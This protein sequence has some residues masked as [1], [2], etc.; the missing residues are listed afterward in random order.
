MITNRILC[1]GALVQRRDHQRD[2]DARGPLTR[3]THRH[4]ARQLPDCY[5]PLHIVTQLVN[6][7]DKMLK[8]FSE[9]SASGS[10]QY[11]PHLFDKVTACNAF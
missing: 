5:L 4:T 11:E 3:R 2:T 8:S 9:A 1:A 10:Y 6:L 7:P